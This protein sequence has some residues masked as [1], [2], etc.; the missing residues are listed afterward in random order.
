MVLSVYDL[1]ALRGAGRLKHLVA[2]MG[3]TLLAVGF[4]TIATGG[5]SFGLLPVFRVAGLALCVVFGA[6][7]VYSLLVELPFGTT[8]KRAGA[9]ES[10]IT[11]GTYALCRHPGVLWFI[12]GVAGFALVVDT[13][14]ALAA[15][16]VWGGLDIAYAF[17]QDRYYF[18]R[19]FGSAYRDYQRTVPFLVPTRRSLR[20]CVRTL[21]RPGTTGASDEKRD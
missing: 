11:T 6:L 5:E 15:V 18:P 1:A 14:A 4:V 17:L 8:Y 3:L 9:P 20:R 10:L 13:R 7:L 19:I 12:G 16:P 21:G 2:L